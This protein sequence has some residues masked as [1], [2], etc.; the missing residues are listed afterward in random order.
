MLD[1]GYR[2]RY[3]ALLRFD[4]SSIPPGASVTEATLAL[5]ANG[6]G[7]LDMTLDVHRVLRGV[8]ICR[9]TW[10][11][12]VDGNN[13]GTAGCCDA[14]TDRGAAPES[15]VTT[16]T[17]R[18]WYHFGLT[19]LVQDWVNGTLANNGVLLRGAVPWSTGK[20]YFISAQDG[21]IRLR[22]KLVITYLVPDSPTATDTATPTPTHAPTV[23]PSATPTST[24]TEPPAA[25]G[26]ATATP[27]HAPTLTP[28]PSPPSPGIETTIALQQ[29]SN[30]YTGCEDTHIY[31]YAPATN[32]CAHNLLYVGYRQQY[33]TLMRFDLAPIPANAIVTEATLELYAVGWSGYDPPID[34]HVILRNV[35][36]CQAT[37]NVAEEGNPWGQPGCNDTATDRHGL[38]ESSL[39]TH[40][41]GQWYS[42]GL[43]AAVQGWLDGSLANNGVLLRGANTISAALRFAAVQNNDLS[44]R[45]RLVVTYR[46]S[47]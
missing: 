23:T 34:T 29:G 32:Y 11:Q 31:L 6:W 9:A 37:W 2:Q 36:L 27:T 25:T 26:T 4:L 16:D 20:F 7:G 43:T 30:G 15:S 10:N 19:A 17:I 8:N 41:I 28:S 39:T 5:Y 33:A 13:W 1:V 3:A 38:P 42:F 14:D 24:T 35:D 47:G 40:G 18:K 45:P 21:T 12:A 44:L 46:T 22:P